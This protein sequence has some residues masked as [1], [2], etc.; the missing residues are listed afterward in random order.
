VRTDVYI[1]A[2]ILVSSSMDASDFLVFSLS[3]DFSI[4]Y[5]G[6]LHFFSLASSLLT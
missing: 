6:K 1:D 4:N 3:V 2:T 5:F